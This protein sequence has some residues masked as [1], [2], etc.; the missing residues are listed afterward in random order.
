VGG[1]NVTRVGDG[2]DENGGVQDDEIPNIDDLAMIE[3]GDN[4]TKK[5]SISVEGATDDILS[6]DDPRN[7]TRLVQI[8]RL[9][10]S[11]GHLPRNRR[12]LEEKRQPNT[13]EEAASDA[14]EK[15]SS[16][17]VDVI[18]EE[19]DDQDNDHVT[20]LSLSED[21][22]SIDSGD[23]D[24]GDDGEDDP[25][26]AAI[27]AAFEAAK[28]GE[29]AGEWRKFTSRPTTHICFVVFVSVVQRLTCNS[30]FSFN[31]S[32]AAVVATNTSSAVSVTTH[33]EFYSRAL[34][35]RSAKYLIFCW[36]RILTPSFFL[37]SYIYLGQHRRRN[38]SGGHRRVESEGCERRGQ[39]EIHGG[40]AFERRW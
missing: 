39:I 19:E 15:T 36:V 28:A 21:A 16:A 10:S 32:A 26:E 13:T 9:T 6:E 12:K 7:G 31:S 29:N 18:N 27:E 5:E 20:G 3:S 38:Q 35:C 24:G 14:P 4:E 2:V 33:S 37:P 23:L 25:A 8:R 17:E 22:T 34:F 1:K 11:Q 30:C 40:S